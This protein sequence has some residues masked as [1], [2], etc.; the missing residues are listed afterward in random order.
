MYKKIEEFRNVSKNNVN[1]RTLLCRSFLRFDDIVKISFEKNLSITYVGT[2]DKA[3]LYLG[4]Y[5]VKEFFINNNGEF[6]VTLF[7]E[8]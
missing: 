3:C 5:N 2:L 7:D 1:L 6:S 8:E 4:D